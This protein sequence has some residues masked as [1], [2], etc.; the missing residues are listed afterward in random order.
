MDAYCRLHRLALSSWQV[1][2]IRALDDAQLK[3][4]A[5]HNEA[6]HAEKAVPRT[7]SKPKPKAR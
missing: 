6:S 3:V 4:M 2:I 1:D 7:K 5:K